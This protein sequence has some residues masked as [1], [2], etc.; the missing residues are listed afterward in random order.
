MD[1]LAWARGLFLA[2]T[3]GLDNCLAIALAAGAFFIGGDAAKGLEGGRA[4][5]EVLVGGRAFLGD[6]KASVRERLRL[7]VG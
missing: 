7:I 1:C 5:F 3:S 6:V 2:C 4:S